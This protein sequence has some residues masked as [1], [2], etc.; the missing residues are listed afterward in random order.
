[1][2]TS[3]L[4]MGQLVYVSLVLVLKAGQLKASVLYS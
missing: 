3:G 4:W 1:M 2:H